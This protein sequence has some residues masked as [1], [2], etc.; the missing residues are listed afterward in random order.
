MSKVLSNIRLS[1]DFFI[2]RVA[3]PNS[4]R[5]GQFHMLRSWGAYP[6]LSRPLSVHD[7]DPETLTFL[8]RTVGQGTKLLSEL[9][10]GDG[11]SVGRSLGNAFP[12]VEGKIAMVGGGV[13][14]APLYLASKSIKN[15][16][17]PTRVD[18]Y[19][20]FSDEALLTDEYAKVSDTVVTDVGGFIT[21]RV[22]PEN[23]DCVLSCGPE[24]MMRALY[25][26][27][28]RTGTKLYVSMEKRMACGFGACLACSCKTTGGRKKVCVDGP[29]FP[30]EEVFE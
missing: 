20:G 15:P 5:M 22:A 27:C 24:A 2:M 25:G 6:L 16:G 30:A 13:G 12:A 21:D 3:A 10:A 26:K 29:V 1:R 7:A 19:L 4:A 11:I 18:M 9:G 17:S 28:K 8:F 23:Y 14:I